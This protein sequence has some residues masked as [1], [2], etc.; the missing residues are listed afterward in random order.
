MK[1]SKT[2][3]LL[4][5]FI[6]LGTILRCIQLGFQDVN[7]D[8]QFTIMWARP[9]LS[10]VQLIINSL[11]IDFTPP[12]Y[13]LAAHFSMLV[14]GATAIAIRIPSM[15]AGILFIPVMYY[16]GKEYRDDWFGL[17]LAGFTTV[18]YS[19]L[20]YSRYGRSYAMAILFFTLAFYF[21]L[22]IRNGDYT[23]ASL[24]FGVFA[25]LSVWTHLYTAIPLGIMILCL[26]VIERKAYSGIALFIIGSLPLLN[27]LFIIRDTRVAWIANQTFGLTQTQVL[28]HTPVYLFNYSVVIVVPI[29]IWAIWKYRADRIIQLIT[30]LSLVTWA[31]MYIL[32]KETPIIGHYAIWC[33]PLLL[34]PLL[35]PFYD[36]YKEKGWDMPFTYIILGLFILITEF[37]QI[38]FL[39]TAQRLAL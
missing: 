20:Y 35:L 36:A 7:L 24:W 25:L 10:A 39:Y 19:F 27:Y 12:L 31:S 32:A 1:L 6:I 14:F 17:L 5:S 22:R 34:I 26:L 28:T 18:F 11:T 13:Y 37:I 38:G 2:D 33:V 15:I 8:E 16:I 9:G 23:R 21:L 3:L 29:L 4:F 30:V